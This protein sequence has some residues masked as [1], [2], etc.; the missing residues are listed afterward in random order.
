L[1]ADW[2]WFLQF[3][4][5]ER[6]PGSFRVPFV[7]EGSFGLPSGFL[8][9]TNNLGGLLSAPLREGNERD[10]A[11]EL[12]TIRKFRL[13]TPVVNVRATAFCWKKRRSTRM[14]WLNINKCG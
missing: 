2:H 9:D 5:D 1:E 3:E 4:R 6:K 8:P 12:E 10:A 13:E 7:S 11:I 14:F